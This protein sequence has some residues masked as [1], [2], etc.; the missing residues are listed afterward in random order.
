MTFPNW[1]SQQAKQNPDLTALIFRTPYKEADGDRY[2][3]T[4][5]LVNYSQSHYWTFAQ[6]EAE[7]NQWVDFLQNLGIKSGD[8]VGLLMA[9][10]PRYVM[11]VHALSRCK[12]I[13]VFLNTRLTAVE[14]K[15]QIQDSQAQYLFHDH[16]HTAIAKVLDSIVQT[17][18][19]DSNFNGNVTSRSQDRFSGMDQNKQRNLEPEV[20]LQANRTEQILAQ[21]YK[22]ADLPIEENSIHGIFY[23][24]GTT[25][26]P[27]GVPLSYGNHW[28]NAIASNS[29]IGA[30]LND[31]WLL[32][33][34]LFHVGGMAII[35]RSVI[36]GMTLTLLPRFDEQQ[37]LEAIAAE[38]VTLISL[39]PT[40]LSRLLEHSLWRN[41][42][43]LRGILLGGANANSE[44]T[45][46]CL[47]LGLPIMP[48]YGMTETASQF[49]TLLPHEA[50]L[51]Q[52]SSGRP[53]SGNQLRI[54]KG[55]DHIQEVNVGEIGQV[56]VRGKSVM[57]GYL[58]RQ[59]NV[60]AQG[61]LH[62][63]DLGYLD[64][65]GYLYVVSRRSDLII[66]GGENI[67]PA[68]IEAILVTHPAINDICVIGLADP[69]WGEQ[70]VAIA[71]TKSLVTLSELR[72]FCE[73]KSLA[74]YKLPKSLLIVDALPRSASGKLLRH[75]I[76]DQLISNKK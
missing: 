34:P 43:N 68:E 67:Y 48:T 54:I 22:C 60:D 72:S 59:V 51:K 21:D 58:H 53:L 47:R 45:N 65:D 23:T 15:F 64:A 18:N 17:I 49:A 73:Q 25:G 24:S 3:D 11:L 27:K 29:R 69:E 55:E 74:R 32:C 33:L 28:H 75:E 37:V 19:S 44:L 13:A 8:R 20:V 30:N 4:E 71:V 40:M 14:I 63:G 5:T 41:L 57:S 50:K 46:R 66:S 52:G 56:L 36:S 9:N 70:V 35:W 38:K 61:W 42:C 26:K 10:H 62:T 39:V 2:Q 12:A 6:L 7:V 16:Q 31:N 76:R 1:L